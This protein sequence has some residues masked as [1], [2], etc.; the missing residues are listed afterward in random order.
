[1]DVTWSL[2]HPSLLVGVVRAEGVRVGPSEPE[3]FAALSARV[4]AAA[5]VGDGVR[6]AIRRLLKHGGFKATGRN[7]PA[8]EYLGEAKR[9]GE[10]PAILN[11]V[12]VNNVLSLETGWPMSVLDLDKC[13]ASLEVRFGRTDERY[14]FNQ[15][16]HA[17]DLEGLFGL[18]Q[19]DGPM[20]GNPVKDA[21]H[22]KLEATTSRLIACLWASREVA[23]PERVRGVA[24]DFAA[25]LRAYC[26]ASDTAVDVLAGPSGPDQK[27]SAPQ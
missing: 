22:A 25:L 13:G 5:D 10:W 23:T 24:E 4:D 21:M 6:Q 26:G 18:A 7:K 1:M 2:D 14:V 3:A 11:A 12:D 20:L 15:A 19:V 9:R 27:S 8:S 17:I 16:G